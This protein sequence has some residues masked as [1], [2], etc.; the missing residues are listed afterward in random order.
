MVQSQFT[1]T[2]NSLGSGDPPTS[3]PQ[4]AR[5]TGACHHTELIFV[6]F[7][8]RDRISFFRQILTLSPRLAC[9][10]MV[11]AQCN[12]CFPG[13]SDFRTSASGV[14]GITDMYHQARLIFVF[15]HVGQAGLELL[16]L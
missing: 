7:S 15:H 14:V 4:V 13:S 8:D 5:T 10:G 16:T 9:S 12:L 6:F 2:S 3:A 11:L 1:A